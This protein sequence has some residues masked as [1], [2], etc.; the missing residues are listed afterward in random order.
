M[1]VPT[2]AARVTEPQ[3]G[4]TASKLTGPF[5][6]FTA[7]VQ[8]TR[9]RQWPKNLLV[10]AAPLAGHTMGRPHGFWYALTA[11]I[12]FVA[13]S[14]AVYLINDVVDAERDRSHPYKKNRPIAAGR[15][16]VRHA[17]VVAVFLV[18][19]A[20]G[21]GLA[22]RAPLLTATI[23]AYLTISFL[24]SA[25][26]KH[27]PIIELGSV[28]SGFVLR[29]IGGAV[30]THVPPSGWFLLVCSLGALMVAIAKRY[31]ELTV[32]G[33]D[34]AKHRPAMRGYSGPALRIAQRVVSAVMIASYIVWAAN[35]PAVRTRVLHLISS[36]ALL[37]AL[38]RFD[39]LTARATSKPV[40]DLI[41]RDPVMAGCE[42]SWL[43]LFALG[44]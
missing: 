33:A 23:A 18:L 27:T 28:A 9:P 11:A 24:Y 44:L 32:L 30:A 40:E 16:P 36:V 4:R 37:A 43:V 21:A 7:V 25:G 34:A 10:F 5:R 6:W 15:L 13:A 42:I 39:R 14:S 20:L 1:T 3:S 2:P 38:V 17:L 22:I 29:V 12:A 31:T 35:E 26:L 41:S 19:A 8:T